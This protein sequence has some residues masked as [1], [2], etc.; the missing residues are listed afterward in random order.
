MNF[1]SLVETGSVSSREKKRGMYDREKRSKRIVAAHMKNFRKLGN[2]GLRGLSENWNWYN[3]WLRDGGK[4][5]RKRERE[6]FGCISHRRG[7][8]TLNSRKRIWE[9]SNPITAFVHLEPVN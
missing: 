8:F 1:I 2:C 4:E 7:S 9:L 3:F 5:T 6:V